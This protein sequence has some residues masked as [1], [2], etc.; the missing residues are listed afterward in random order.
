MKPFR[1]IGLTVA[2]AAFIISYSP[3]QVFAQGK[4]STNV[5][6]MDLSLQPE[7]HGEQVKIACLGDPDTLEVNRG[8]IVI[9]RAVGAKVN[10]V[11]WAGK[12]AK[13]EPLNANMANLSDDTLAETPTFEKGAAWAIRVNDAKEQDGGIPRGRPAYTLDV[14]CGDLE[15][16]PPVIIVDP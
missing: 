7:M 14:M 10:H 5:H 11:R 1:C 2:I 6:F 9:F 16:G 12:N 15:D 13:G 8:D 3:G 4:K